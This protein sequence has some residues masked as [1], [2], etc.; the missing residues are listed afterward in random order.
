MYIPSLVLASTPTLRPYP[1]GSIATGGTA[2]LLMPQDPQ[3]YYIAIQNT[4]D[5]VM[6]VGIGA[7][8][9]TA[10]LTS[11]AVSSVSV[12]NAGMG[13][14]YAPKVV[15]VNGGYP[16]T[17]NPG[18]P[19]SP[20]TEGVGGGLGPFQGPTRTASAV[21]VMTGSAGALTIASITVQDGGAGYQAAPYVYLQNDPRDPLGCFAPSATVGWYLAANGGS[22]T[23][24]NNAV[25][26]D[27]FSIFCA[28]SSKTFECEVY[29]RAQS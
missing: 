12:V 18:S 6:R 24:E 8:T 4:S 19:G 17:P 5:T 23:W 11:G 7:A 25:T 28:S 27:A 20:W 2:Q 1:A 14:T 21:C 9:A 3:R 26:T 13:F 10:A 22:R 15:F 29:S 16:S